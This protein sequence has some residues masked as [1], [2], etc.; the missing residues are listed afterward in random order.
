MAVT[1]STKQEIERTND[2]SSEDSNDS[3]TLFVVRVYFCREDI[4]NNR[5][6][7][8]LNVVENPDDWT[9]QGRETNDGDTVFSNVFYREE[10]ALFRAWLR[11]TPFPLSFELRIEH[12]EH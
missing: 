10:Y 6:T 3:L 2:Y 1:R 12:D 5:H 4:S 8:F 11:M 7:S 9:R